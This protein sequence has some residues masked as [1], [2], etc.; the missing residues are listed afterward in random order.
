MEIYYLIAGLT[1]LGLIFAILVAIFDKRDSQDSSNSS[2][3]NSNSNTT[4]GSSDASSGDC[5]TSSCT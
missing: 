3:N 4:Y 2:N 1:T 5:G